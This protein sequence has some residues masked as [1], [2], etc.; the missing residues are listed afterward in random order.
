[1]ID[2]HSHILPGIDDGAADWADSLMLARAAV[3]EGITDIIAT[4]HHYDRK[5]KN[6]ADQV[7]A[8]VNELN[9]RLNKQDIPLMV[10]AGQEIHI[11]EELLAHLDEGNL[12]KLAN[13]DYMLLEM[14][15]SRI[16]NAMEH[17]VYELC[18]AGIK[19]IIAHPERNAE[20]VKHPERLAA[21]IELGAFAQVTS[22]SLLGG[23]GRE[24]ERISWELCRQGLIHFIASDAHNL[25]WR[26]F[27]MR[28]SF[29]KTEEVLGVSTAAA[30]ARNAELL[31]HNKEVGMTAIRQSERRHKGWSSFRS[32][33]RK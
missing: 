5:Y 10:H 30:Y 23:F 2:I 17:I 32:L 33:F 3:A 27:R 29:E 21:L 14:P 18:L 11:H 1:M 15:H 28:E 13:S 24:I 12:L 20:V 19:P 4:P 7:L 25:A 16:P 6:D 22:H 9:D 26:G 8:L 31:L